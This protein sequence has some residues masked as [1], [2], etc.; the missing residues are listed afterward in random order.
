MIKQLEIKNSILDKQSLKK[1]LEQ[2]S[3]D[4]K[5]INS[6]DKN[7][8]PV[9]RVIENK[10]YIDLVCKLLTEH[11]KLKLPIHPAGEWLLDNYYIIE[12]AVKVIQKN[13]TISKYLSL[14]AIEGSGFV[15]IYEIANEIISYTDA[16]ITEDDLIEYLEAYQVQ[17][18]LSMQEIWDIGLF[19]QICIVEKIRKISEK[20]FETQIQRYKAQNLV[21]RLVDQKKEKKINIDVNSKYSFI[22]YL[23]YKL[24]QYGKISIPYI[25]ALDNEIRKSGMTLDDVISR[26]HFD[27]ALKTLSM[28]NS[29]TALKNIERFNIV[30][31]FERTCEVEKILKTDSAKIYEKMDFSTK[32]YYRNEIL[33]IAKK[34]KVS[35][36]YVAQTA[37]QLCNENFQKNN[38]TQIMQ[39]QKL[40]SIN[41]NNENNINNLQ[42]KAN[43]NENKNLGEK[44][45][46][47]ENTVAKIKQYENK[48][49]TSLPNIN[50]KNFKNNKMN[51]KALLKLFNSQ[52]EIAKEIQIEK[53]KKNF[54]KQSELVNFKKSHIG[55]YLID[56]GKKELIQK[57]TNKK[58]NIMNN[59]EKARLYVYLILL[60]SIF[61]ALILGIWLKW[62]AI[63]LF[64]PIQNM[65]TKIFQYNLCKI[66]KPKVLPKMDYQNCIPKEAATM[67]VI[68]T[69][70]KSKEE[71]TE[72]VQKMEEYYLANKS[73]NLYFTLL[74][75]CTNSDKSKSKNDKEIIDEGIQQTKILNQKY[76]TKFFFV[77]RKRE[78]SNSEKCFMGW[79]RKRGYLNQFNDFLLGKKV[80]FFENTLQAD[81]IE[82]N[83]EIPKIKYV[84][85]L[86]SD[87]K[88][89]LNSAFKLVGTID[90]IL[91]KPEI[92]KIKNI[93]IKGYGIIQ[94]RIGIETVSGRK[95]LFSK[96]FS[97]EVGADIYANAIS[98]V[99]QDNFDEGT[100]TGKGIYNL[101]VFDKVLRNSIPENQVLSHDLIEGAYLRC[102]LAS[103]IVLMDDMPSNY[104]SY[105]M[106]KERWARGD[107]QAIPWLKSGLNFLSKYKIKD[108]INRNFNSIFILLSFVI[109][110]VKS[111]KYVFLPLIFLI[112]PVIIE[113][114]DSL[115]IDAKNKIKFHT[116]SKNFSPIEKTILQAFVKFITL[117]DMAFTQISAFAKSIYR[118]K[119]SHNFLL[120]WT[121]S[122]EAESINKNSLDF[123]NENMLLQILFS[124][125]LICV[126]SI[127]TAYSNIFKL[128]LIMF[129]LLW[130]IAPAIMRNL[131]NEKNDK[132]NVKNLLLKNEEQ[133]DSVNDFSIKEDN[134]KGEFKITNSIKYS[135]NKTNQTADEYLLE[136][137]KRTWNYFKENQVN[138]L[139]ADN[140]QEDRT[141][142]LALRTS[143]TNIGFSLLA[144]IA[145]YDLKFESL[146]N[147]IKYIENEITTVEKLKKWNG[148]LFNWYDIKT[149]EPLAPFDI[150]SVDMGN[151]VGY[152]YVVKAF[153][154]DIVNN[155][156]EEKRVNEKIEENNEISKY[157][158][159]EKNTRILEE[160]KNINKEQENIQQKV[161][162]NADSIK[163]LINRIDKLL[164]NADFSKLY[165]EKIGLFSIGYNLAEGKLYDSYY[166]LLASEAR[167]TS[168]VAIAKRDV[169]A[170]HWANLGRTLTSVNDYRGLVSWGGTAFEYL[171][172]NIV[173]PTYENTLIDESCR[174][175]IYSN[176]QYAKKLG[177][178]WGISESAYS[179]KDLYGNYQ[180][181]TFGIP[182]LGLKRGLENDVVVS[183]YSSALA[184]PYAKNLI[185]ENFKKL[186]KEKMLGKFGF[187][188][189]IDYK[190]QKQVVKTFMAHHQGM[191]L[192]SI[193]NS[194]NNNIFQKRFMQNPEIRGTQILLE[195]K[196]PDDEIV[197]KEKKEK[198][199]KVNY[200]LYKEEAPRTSGINIL[201]KNEI[202]NIQDDLG[203]ETTKFEDIVID[204][205]RQI[206]I[207]DVDS[208]EIMDVKENLISEENL[209]HLKINNLDKIN[210]VLINQLSNISKT[211]IS[212]TKNKYDEDTRNYNK[213]RNFDP[214]EKSKIEIKNNTKCEF[215]PYKT[216]FLIENQKIKCTV[217][218]TIAPDTNVIVKKIE[219]KNCENKTQNFEITTYEDVILSNIN[220]YNSHP[221]FDKMFL[222]FYEENG[223]IIIE[224]K[225]RMQNEKCLCTA[226]EILI[227]GEVNEEINKKINEEI[228]NKNFEY[229][230]DK[231]KIVKREDINFKYQDANDDTKY[232][233]RNLESSEKHSILGKTNVQRNI[234][235]NAIKSEYINLL[236]IKN[237]QEMYN[238]KEIF[239][240][241]PKFSSKIEKVINPVVAMRVKIKIPKGEKC[242]IYYVTSI[243]RTKEQAIETISTY[244]N[245]EKL[246]RVF[247]LEKNQEKAQIRYL[248]LTEKEISKFQT[249]LFQILRTNQ[250]IFDDNALK[251]LN[252]ETKYIADESPK[253]IKESSKEKNLINLDE[254]NV[255][256]TNK[257]IFENEISSK[258][259][260]NEVLKNEIYRKFSEVDLSNNVLWKFGISGD[261]PLIV[262]E[263]DNKNNLFYLKQILREFEYFKTINVQ[264]ELAIITKLNVKEEIISEKMGKYLNERSGI[265]IVE[266]IS[267][268]EKRT[269]ELRAA[270]VVIAG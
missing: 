143:P 109:L 61:T 224:R 208:N 214:K 48:S 73:E 50:L 126:T 69:I 91:N 185:V 228:I 122:K 76:E 29:I 108:N 177:I 174:L 244:E 184:L 44:Q 215:T 146:E 39:V 5:I 188:D 112:Y 12:K 248:G 74:G 231:E 189:S 70:L 49:I 226:K 195:E 56:E 117:P 133:K 16:N 6:P 119:F 163:T 102:G 258:E 209:Y 38:I 217:N 67:C 167:Q 221:A 11:A 165:N 242:E 31:I 193:D 55:Y 3:A 35:E 156:G 219:L 176:L 240:K 210:N 254:E 24:R 166:D 136:I 155:V 187:Y 105:K 62:V 207:K 263:I 77:Y 196:M 206:F 191:I 199:Q 218:T 123:Y 267:I 202:S 234:E 225:S 84:I 194:L 197:T 25:E 101:S 247:E 135:K 90:H 9:E 94:P 40:N 173:I 211:N 190:P 270:K 162:L 28:K 181:K 54:D 205:N 148:H 2:F 157:E 121:T 27:I 251:M 46:N 259:N 106:R 171:M 34:C 216:K 238:L 111:S 20:I 75:D 99:Y 104:I 236:T 268:K 129:E 103:D 192:T 203:Y 198:V 266:N 150:S 98:D 118:M 142:K 59:E 72:M 33:E 14:P 246:E 241:S 223:K 262:L 23:S 269:L 42:Q 124:V 204:K 137:A 13:L 78:W 32:E 26:E 4:N 36:I 92:D 21:N 65:I 213:E 222:K 182:W 64:I 132:Y 138:Y 83:Q 237:E 178:P 140:F 114:I 113:L 58:I 96:I 252:Q 47:N 86:D 235:N 160:N 159:L 45:N 22:E 80:E 170:K 233:N 130:I 161:I 60:V 93:V 120:E 17:K 232:Q 85:T 261:F 257:N 212:N 87:T 8:F 51:K 18:K 53:I 141:E 131:S 66:K 116:F 243:G 37:I 15:R 147:T 95:T 256:N 82:K 134:S 230:I 152:L 183:P 220:Q 186:E 164:E 43:L 81:F 139:P 264:T 125:I 63:L 227:N 253:E 239:Q 154:N 149:L 249:D 144:A 168:I 110:L 250:E 245:S 260:K 57:I 115:I 200:S 19:L 179:V 7:T 145:S 175:L 41:E 255:G 52:Y 180:Y 10:N 68:P 79:E 172:P 127:A 1:Y 229:E 158:K 100:F 128:I 265:F 30:K 89:T 88:L 169:P 153:L 71:T 97:G 201:A 107:T 151:F